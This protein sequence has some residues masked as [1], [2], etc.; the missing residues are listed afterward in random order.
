MLDLLLDELARTFYCT[1]SR[2]QHQQ[3]SPMLEHKSISEALTPVSCLDRP[4]H[5]PEV[6]LNDLTTSSSST[7][8]RPDQVI[9]ALQPLD[10][11]GTKFD[12]RDYLEKE[13]KAHHAA[14]HLSLSAPNGQTG[15]SPSLSIAQ[16]DGFKGNQGDGMR[17]ADPSGHLHTGPMGPVNAQT[18]TTT[19]TRS[20]QDITENNNTKASTW[21]TTTNQVYEG[22]PQLQAEYGYEPAYEPWTDDV[23]LQELDRK[24]AQLEAS[25]IDLAPAPKLKVPRKKKLCF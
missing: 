19:T 4:I 8:S 21:P 20:S 6:D 15:P 9:P 23:A 16:C 7:C 12:T 11:D 5:A 10:V 2:Y 24:I 25:V 14:T 22:E 13:T 1:S 3:L 18:T 17:S